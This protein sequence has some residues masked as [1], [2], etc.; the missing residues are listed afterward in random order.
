MSLLLSLH[1]AA[2]D[3]DSHTTGNTWICVPSCVYVLCH[4]QIIRNSPWLNTDEWPG[5]LWNKVRTQH[6][7]LKNKQALKGEHMALNLQAA[8]LSLLSA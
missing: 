4:A 6:T 8:I 7:K 5:H 2:L 3:V 1:C